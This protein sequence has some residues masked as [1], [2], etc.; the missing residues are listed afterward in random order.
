MPPNGTITPEKLNYSTEG[1][2]IN[3]KTI[4]HVSLFRLIVIQF[5]T[6]DR[7][8]PAQTVVILAARKKQGEATTMRNIGG[9]SIS[10]H[11]QFDTVSDLCLIPLQMNTS[12]RRLC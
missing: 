5:Q 2:P 12:E 1:P 6:T 9:N 8:C 3:A 10:W 4:L 7:I 11:N